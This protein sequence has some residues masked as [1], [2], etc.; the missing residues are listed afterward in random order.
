MMVL[1]L[2]MVL[3][4]APVWSQTD[5]TNAETDST[6]TAEP[7]YLDTL[8][9]LSCQEL[10]RVFYREIPR[11]VYDDLPDELY[12]LVIFATDECDFGEPLIRTQILAS[13]WDD[14]FQE[15]IY[16]YDVIGA[17]A[18]RYDPDNVAAPGSEREVFA[19]F[20][21][22]FASQ[23]LPHVPSR[24]LEEFF[25]LYYSGHTDDA[26]EL[27]QSEDLENTWLRYYYDEQIDQLSHR[28]APYIVGVHWGGWLPGGDLE[29]VRAKHLVGV[30]V[31]Q[32]TTW[33]YLRFVGEGRIGRAGEPYIVEK[34][35]ISGISDRWNA[36]LF[37]IDI[38]VPVWRFGP[39]LA[40]A[41]VGVGYDTVHPLKDQEIWS[42][43][44]NLNL[45]VGYRWYPSPSRTWFAKI[46]GRY[47]WIGSRNT[48]GTSLEG[49]AWSTRLGLGLA[50]GK[51]PEPRLTAL[52]QRD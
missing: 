8:S 7:Y 26:W 10:E 13:I 20:T 14:N 11:A 52:G 22:D 19:T 28:K 51:N 9:D 21:T 35:G 4:A 49:H 33:G 50:L 31:E 42:A 23:M 5:P 38:G 27:L 12:Q 17:L 3:V 46:D 37:G 29:F 32:W 43:T 2:V 41:F 1:V 34:E 24:S 47:E 15:V 6:A 48:G 44:I 40:E 30:T 45:G 36:L 39:H 18:D 16:G 25:C